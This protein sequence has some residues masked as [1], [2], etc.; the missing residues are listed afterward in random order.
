MNA[1]IWDNKFLEHLKHF[2]KETISNIFLEILGPKIYRVQPM[3]I[4][5][6]T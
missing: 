5:D 2:S 6:S 4:E 1:I 3:R